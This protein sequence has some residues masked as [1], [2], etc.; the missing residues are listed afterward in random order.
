V[1]EKSRPI[2]NETSGAPTFQ[3]SA[4]RNFNRNLNTSLRLG[5]VRPW[6]STSGRAQILAANCAVF[7]NGVAAIAEVS[8]HTLCV[9]RAIRACPLARAHVRPVRWPADSQGF[10]PRME[11]CRCV[12]G[13]FGSDQQKTRRSIERRVA[14]TV[15][16][17]CRV[18]RW[19]TCK[20]CRRDP[21]ASDLPWPGSEDQGL[22]QHRSK[23]GSLF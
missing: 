4:L 3:G 22:S 2:Y 7:A 15:P 14:W 16:P 11:P 10:S 12:R 9:I 6:V 20:Y 21:S 19:T 18:R 5:Q 8:D 13:V 1:L 17:L 23:P